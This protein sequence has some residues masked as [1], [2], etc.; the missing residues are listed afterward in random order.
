MKILEKIKLNPVM[1]K[2]VIDAPLIARRAKAGQF[3]IVKI[4]EPGE[5]IPLTIND[6]DADKCE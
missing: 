3:V 1:W 5:R 2:M 4:D 6:N